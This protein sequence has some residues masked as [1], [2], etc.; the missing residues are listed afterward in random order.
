MLSLFINF[1][2]F[3]GI[4]NKR[5]N[6]LNHLFFHILNIRKFYDSAVNHKLIEWTIQTS[7]LAKQTSYLSI[8]SFFNFEQKL[9]LL[10]SHFM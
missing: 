1:K 7:N 9:S 3:M 2:W 5:S 4:I 8:S 6:L 10:N